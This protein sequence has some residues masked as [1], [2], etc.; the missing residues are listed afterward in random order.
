MRILVTALVAAFLVACSPATVPAPVPTPTPTATPA[1]TA[2]PTTAPTPTVTATPIALLVPG[3]STLAMR[4]TWD[5]ATK[6]SQAL[7]VLVTSFHSPDDV[8]AY[9]ASHCDWRDTYDTSHFLSP[10]ELIGQGYGVCTA[11]ARFWAFALERQGYRVDVVSVWGPE[12]AHS[13]AV[14]RDAGGHYRLASNQ[15]WSDQTDLGP[16]RDAAIVR[17]AVEFFGAS[18][19][20]I[21]VH[22][23]DSGIIRQRIDHDGVPAA[24]IAPPGRNIFTIRR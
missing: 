1:P 15:Q 24:D 8:G 21:L 9:L 18:W 23:P 7:D 11:F 19:S 4:W 12:S 13:I 17:S 20:T 5:P 6:P 22:D 3:S 14:W 16:E 10:D 2:T